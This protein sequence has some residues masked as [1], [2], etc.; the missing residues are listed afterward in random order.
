MYV[1]LEFI[2]VEKKRKKNAILPQE[3]CV[4]V[5]MGQS[6]VSI[7]KRPKYRQQHG[8]EQQSVTYVYRYIFINMYIY[9]YMTV[10]VVI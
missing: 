9:M 10:N 6:S 4:G 7:E 2:K 3:I 1:P 5:P 8:R